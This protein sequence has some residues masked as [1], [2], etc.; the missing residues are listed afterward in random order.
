MLPKESHFQEETITSAGFPLRKDSEGVDE[1][2]TICDRF[3]NNRFELVPRRVTKRATVKVSSPREC[4]MHEM[5]HEEEQNLNRDMRERLRE[6]RSELFPRES[7]FFQSA[8]NWHQSPLLC[9]SP[10]PN[11][12]KE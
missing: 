11:T 12:E 4:R 1:R 9:H 8:R 10:N 7:Q 6:R 2:A 3:Y 5:L